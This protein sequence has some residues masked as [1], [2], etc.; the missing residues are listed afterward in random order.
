MFDSKILS[1]SMIVV[2]ISSVF[3]F[4][5]LMSFFVRF[6]DY[7]DFIVYIFEMIMAFFLFVELIS[8]RII[9]NV[10]SRYKV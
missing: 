8:A 7:V 3:V 10:L 5:I 4:E 9:R 6:L 1:I 2:E